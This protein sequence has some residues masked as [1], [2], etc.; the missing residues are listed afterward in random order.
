MSEVIARRQFSP[1]YIGFDIAFLLV[2]AG[3]LLWRKKYM[4]VLIGVLFGFVYMAVDY[5]IFHLLTHSRTISEGYSL[6]W[7]LLWM[8]MSYGFTN[9]A[10][11]W[12][13]LSK[14]RRLFEWSLLIL[15]WWFCCP[16]LTQ[17]FAPRKMA[18]KAVPLAD[19]A[20]TVGALAGAADCLRTEEVYAGLPLGEPM[21]VF[22]GFYGDRMNQALNAMRRT[23]L[24]SPYKAMLTAAN[25]GWR[26]AELFAELQKEHAAMTAKR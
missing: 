23:G 18:V 10:W 17:T 5:G 26:P 9:F 8:S 14:D 1:G 6:F 12:L 15:S 20:Q 3:L 2:F 7:V 24:R 11:I 4:T 16:L 21:L 13:W 22:C 19:Y 25:R